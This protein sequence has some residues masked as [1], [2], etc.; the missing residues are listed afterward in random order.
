MKSYNADR[1]EAQGGWLKVT[2]VALWCIAG[3]LAVA[4][5]FTWGILP[6]PLGNDHTPASRMPAVRSDFN[7]SRLGSATP[8]PEATT[9]KPG[10]TRKR[11]PASPSPS[12]TTPA[13]SASAP[14]SSA[15]PSK[16][17]DPVIPDPVVTTTSPT[18]PPG[19]EEPD[20]GG[21]TKEPGPGEWIDLPIDPQLPIDDSANTPQ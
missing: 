4:N 17:P 10:G 1:A 3:V 14:T 7:S 13:P 6:L 20:P 21:G 2:V 11:P 12:T 8:T 5:V 18:T 15:T 19:G 9:K 16:A